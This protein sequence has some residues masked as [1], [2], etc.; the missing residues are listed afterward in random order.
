MQDLCISAQ[1]YVQ[2]LKIIFP[3]NVKIE[4]PTSVWCLVGDYTE[5]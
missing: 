5:G 4:Q 3:D 1:A 2:M